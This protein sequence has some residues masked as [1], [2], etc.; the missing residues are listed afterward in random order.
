L[1]S[2]AVPPDEYPWIEKISTTTSY[3]RLRDGIREYY[4]RNYPLLPSVRMKLL[5]LM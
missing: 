4:R 1:T 3:R 5:L 2:Q